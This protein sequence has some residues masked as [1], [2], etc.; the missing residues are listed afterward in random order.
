MYD[1][2]YS[3]GCSL[4]Y[5]LTLLSMNVKAR[6]NAR[7][8]VLVYFYEQYFLENAATK[9]ALLDEIDKI[10]KVVDQKAPAQVHVDMKGTM[11]HDYYGKEV[12]QEIAYIVENYFRRFEEGEIDFDY[13]DLIAPKFHDYQPVVRDKVNSFT[14]TFGYDEMDLIDRVLFV[15]GY[16]EYV[17]LRTP[18][19]VVLNEMVEL[20]K[21]YGDDSSS[22][23]IN[24]IG[25][26]LLSSV[27]EDPEGSKIP[28]AK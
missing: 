17:E 19:E 28:S 25:H 14:V 11:S 3:P 18:K 7:K 20:A 16:I 12:D 13:I 27:D 26:K 1:M 9:D 2:S 24:G 21:R 6:I 4:A 23:L 22:K 10:H 8:V 15:L 5:S